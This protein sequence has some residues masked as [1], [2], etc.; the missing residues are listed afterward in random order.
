MK[1]KAARH[2]DNADLFRTLFDTAP[3]AM[4]VVDGGGRI[5]LANPQAETLFGYDPRGLHGLQVEALLPENVR[6][7]HATHRSSYMTR[8][9]VRPMGAGYELTGIRRNGEPFPVEIGL[10]PIATTHGGTLYAA[11][12]RDIS[13]TQRARR[14]LSRARYDTFLAQVGRLMLESPHYDVA[15]GSIPS[16]LA[17]ALGTE[18]VAIL[19]RN[20]RYLG[21][22]LHASSG[23]PPDLR[24]SLPEALAKDELIDRL[25]GYSTDAA[26]LKQV[27]VEAFPATRAAIGDAGFQDAALLP[28]L[29][30]YEPTGILIALSRDV[31]SFDHDRLHFLQSVANMLAAVL[32]RSRSEEQLAHSQRLDALGQLTGGIAHD[33][34]NQLTVISGNLQILNAELGDRP[35]ERETMDHALRAVDR[36]TVLT[37]KLLGFARNR[38][39]VTHAL[40]P[41]Q[42][43]TDLCEMLGRTLGERIAVTLDR[44]TGLPSIYADPGELDAALVNLALNARDA[45]SNGGRLTISAHLRHVD[46]EHAAQEELVAGDYVAFGVADTGTGMTHEVLTHAL[47]PFFT[48]KEVGRGSGLGLS[49]V[50]G[51]VKQS[52][53]RMTIDSQVGHGT[54]V[55]LLLPTVPAAAEKRAASGRKAPR[56][57]H[58]TVLVVEDEAEVRRIA[59]AFLR[60]LGYT[61]YEAG[62]ARTAL[63]LLAR[64]PHIE[65][66]FSDV[67]LGGGMT[68]FELVREA[69]RLYPK[70]PALLTSGY[71]RSS[72]GV[73]DPSFRHFR[74]LRKPY[75]REQLAAAVRKSLDRGPST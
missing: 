29:D 34:N 72:M 10:S 33:F 38:R 44:P 61:T 64:T 32:Q 22:H 70:L 43:L 14:A 49:M 15:M 20:P 28:L 59:V 60:S 31:G 42:V 74:L 57:G 54:Y 73:D 7:V 52:R 4:I 71:E 67:M 68:G 63:D 55:E 53:G 16:L 37:R 11:S 36:C 19:L 6:V 23:L 50:Y 47:E 56:K 26:T 8:P 18:A 45:M 65:L 51:F 69:S 1:V 48:T 39:L 2:D 24:E 58:E 75:R 30:R 9:R 35:E 12:I 13:E 66:L 62:D 41:D 46:D 3:D 5:V 17:A 21:S 40:R 27:P 25:T